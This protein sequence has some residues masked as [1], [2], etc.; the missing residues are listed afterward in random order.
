MRDVKKIE[1]YDLKKL[2]PSQCEVD[3]DIESKKDW[4]QD[5]VYIESGAI[6]PLIWLHNIWTV[7]NIFTTCQ[8]EHII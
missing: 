1:I 2:L 7:P 3:N 8:M 6:N 4:G 5:Q